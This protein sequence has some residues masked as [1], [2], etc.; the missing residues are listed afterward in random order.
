MKDVEERLRL[1]SS[2]LIFILL[3]LADVLALSGE[4]MAWA[5]GAG[6][7]GRR[8]LGEE[9]EAEGGRGRALMGRAAA[10]AL[11][12]TDSLQHAAFPLLQHMLLHTHT[13]KNPI[14][15]YIF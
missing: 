8:G 14:Y 7:G 6:R 3:I 11:T 2:F 15:I 10:R 13:Q 1:M 12:R 4:V 5:L 9:R